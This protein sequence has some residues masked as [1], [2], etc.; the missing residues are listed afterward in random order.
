MHRVDLCPITLHWRD[1]GAVIQVLACH[2]QSHNCADL[3]RRS[4]RCSTLFIVSFYK[5]AGRRHFQRKTLPLALHRHEYYAQ[6]HVPLVRTIAPGELFR[7][8]HRKLSESG[9]IVSNLEPSTN[10]SL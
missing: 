1:N 10:M 7:A 9:E 4:C 5:E 8:D 3:Y 6:C 2:A